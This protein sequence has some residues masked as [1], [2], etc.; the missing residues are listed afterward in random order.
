MLNIKI[1]ATDILS[2][3]CFFYITVFITR[4]VK[5]NLNIKKADLQLL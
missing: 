1:S 2:C 5:T 3:N 4:K